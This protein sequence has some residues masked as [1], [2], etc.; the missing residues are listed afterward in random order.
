MINMKKFINNLNLAGVSKGT[1]MRGI[2]ML[3]VVIN[4]ILTAAGLNP[5]KIDESALGEV[6]TVGLTVGTFVASYWQNNSWTK[7]AQE[8]DKKLEELKKE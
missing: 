5:V 2:L 1:V 8:A 6:V 7:A 3:L 4:Y